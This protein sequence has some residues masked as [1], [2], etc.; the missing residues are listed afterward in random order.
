MHILDSLQIVRYIKN[1]KKA[2][3]ICKVNLR[4]MPTL[5]FSLLLLFSACIFIS[6]PNP[7]VEWIMEGNRNSETSITGPYTYILVTGPTPQERTILLGG[8][9][10]LTVTAST[11]PAGGG[12]FTFTY[13]WYHNNV[14]IPGATSASLNIP[15]NLPGGSITVGTHYFYCVVSAPGAASVSS[16][17][18][19]V[20]VTPPEPLN[21]IDAIRAY[22]RAHT[23]GASIANPI[24]LPIALGPINN[25]LELMQVIEDEGKF[26]RLDMAATTMMAASFNPAPSDSTGKNRIVS[27]VLP[28]TST[29]IADGTSTISTFAHFDNLESVSGAN[30]ISIGEGAFWNCTSLTTAHFPAATSIGQGAFSSCTSLTTAHFP[31]VTSI[32]SAAFFDCTSLTTVSFPAATSI[33]SS[34]FAG[35]TSLTTVSFPAVTSIGWSAFFDCTSLTTAHFPAATSIGNSAFAGCTSLIS[36]N[37]PAATSIDEGAFSGCFS[38][39]SVYFPLV[40][41]I[42]NFAFRD[43][44]SLSSANFP[45]ATS[46]GNSAFNGCF[47][48]IS[49]YFPAAA[50]I[51]NLAFMNCT[52]LT[53]AH[54]PAVTSI[55][56]AAF[57]GCTVLADVTLG[58]ITEANFSTNSGFPGDLRDVYFGANGGAGRYTRIHPGIN[59]TKD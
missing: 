14:L 49:V 32:G 6:C 35:C 59:W 31:L 42:G 36:A 7:M 56:N 53:T 24:D 10:T 50:S 20:T 23:D 4:S 28:D 26:V 17:V 48:L 25:W 33:D 52:S 41:S 40:T 43:C 47:S 18:A 21:N 27:I 39:I 22:L 44:T 3:P 19:V 9:T 54:F 38:L 37:F 58:A 29:S 12:P 34:A 11:F 1:M 51:G 45:A 46:I 8:T 13:Q 55:G 16:D 5:L 2:M 57:N 30:V 15:A